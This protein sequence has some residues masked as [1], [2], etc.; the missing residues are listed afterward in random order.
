MNQITSSHSVQ[1][2]TSRPPTTENSRSAYS[3][4][5]TDIVQ[6]MERGDMTPREISDGRNRIGAELARLRWRYGQL[7]AKRAKY[8][9]ARRD[10]YKSMAETERAWEA[11][12]EGQIELQMHHQIKALEGLLSALE[13]NWFLLQGEAS[14]KW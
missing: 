11:T 3:V 10:N 7:V 6:A 8:V 5:F 1:G 12:D 14:N 4:N 2:A 9:S 13:T